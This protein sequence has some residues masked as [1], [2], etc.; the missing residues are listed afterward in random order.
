[1]KAFISY[2]SEH[3]NIAEKIGVRVQ[4]LV[5]GGDPVQIFFDRQNLNPGDGYDQ[6]ISDEMDSSDI[7]IVLVAEETYDHGSYT[8][9]EIDLA[10]KKWPDPSGRILPVLVSNKNVQNKNPYVESVTYLQTRGNLPAQAAAEAKRMLEQIYDQRESSARERAREKGAGHQL[11]NS[12]SRLWKSIRGVFYYAVIAVR[13]RPYFTTLLVAIFLY[14]YLVAPK[15]FIH[16]VAQS[17]MDESYFAN[18]QSQEAARRNEIQKASMFSGACDTR[19]TGWIC[20]FLNPQLENPVRSEIF[21]KVSEAEGRTEL[22]VMEAEGRANNKV[23]AVHA[24]INELIE[25]EIKKLKRNYAKMFAENQVQVDTIYTKQFTYS[26]PFD[27]AEEFSKP[28]FDITFLA[29]P[30]QVVKIRAEVDLAIMAP[31]QNID[32]SECSPKRQKEFLGEKACY[33][34]SK[35]DVNRLG[36]DYL[37]NVYLKNGRNPDTMDLDLERDVEIT[38]FLKDD[39]G[40]S[41]N[42][43]AD[44][45]LPLHTISVKFRGLVWQKFTPGSVLTIDVNIIATKNFDVMANN[46]Q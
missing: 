41:Y 3:R 18:G 10:Q 35:I 32:I 31:Q 17:L 16:F 40:F 42:E 8:I 2:P 1:M 19:L 46:D 28:N 13:Q 26:R 27:D 9:N 25:S 33:A 6:K 29:H 5:V 30:N 36:D 39:F 37:K 7:M 21:T 23:N 34:L 11:L 38:E 45:Q 15:H 44:R 43:V 4:Q 12:L 22:K 20:D 14:G 24:Q